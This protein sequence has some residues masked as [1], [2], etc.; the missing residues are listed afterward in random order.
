MRI[1]LVVLEEIFSIRDTTAW[2]L[3]PRL[4][5]ALRHLLQAMFGNIY[6]RRLRQY[7]QWATS[8]EQV[9][10]YLRTLR[11]N[12]WPNGSLALPNPPRDKSA[13]KRTEIAAKASLLSFIPGDF[14][15]P[16]KK[17]NMM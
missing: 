16:K 10:N 15:I 1:L 4:V 11:N 5:S 2:R 7:L 13:K 6:N 9:A 3:R 12:F 8:Y 17:K 14:E